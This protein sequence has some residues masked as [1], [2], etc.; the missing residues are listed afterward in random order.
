MGG[1]TTPK[2]NAI[3]AEVAN[4]I[5]VVTP[6]W[7]SLAVVFGETSELSKICAHSSTTT[8]G[9]TPTGLLE[10]DPRDVRDISAVRKQHGR[11]SPP[12]APKIDTDS[13][14]PMARTT[15][16]EI[17][18]APALVN[19]EPRA[20]HHSLELDYA[21]TISESAFLSPVIAGFFSGL[22]ARQRTPWLVV[23][24]RFKDD[25]PIV[26]FDGLPNGK[27]IDVLAHHRR[28]FTKAGTGT[29]NMVDYFLD[30]SHGKIDVSDSEVVGVYTIPYKR[31][32]YI[33]NVATAAGQ[34]RPRRSA[35]CRTGGG[36]RP[37]DRPDRV[38]GVVVCGYTPLDLCGWVGGMAALCD[39]NS[40]SPDLL[41]QEMGHGYGSDHSGLDGSTQ[42]TATPGIR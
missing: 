20:H 42:S 21:T 9:Q 22:L 35:R 40:L 4:P 37:Q 23:V 36:I 28:L 33:G 38:L 14:D 31:A 39:L 3:G 30:N 13:G 26:V 34:D 16:P 29:M 11:I 7:S 18:S 5:Q 32:D 2:L 27:R 17:S 1:A 12:G 6:P 24:I 25:P 41:G 15:K 19:V 10:S 8:T